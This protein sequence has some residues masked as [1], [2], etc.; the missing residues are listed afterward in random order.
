MEQGGPCGNHRNAPS[1]RH[2]YCVQTKPRA[3]AIALEHLQ[4]Q[5]FVCR[6]PRLR[7]CT[8]ERGHRHVR[9]EALFPR[10][11][12]LHA[13]ATEQSL[14]PVR[15]TRGALGLVRFGGLPALVPD[16]LIAELHHAADADDTL[17][18]HRHDARV[19]DRVCI[20]EGALAGLP[21]QFIEAPAA[22]RAVLLIELLGRSQRIEL[23]RHALYKLDADLAA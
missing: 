9:I 16:A 14:A 6:L 17:T 23:P 15:S 1:T 18:D 5:D 12:F 2:W 3:E 4:R 11:L 13:D 22:D 10:Y 7:R 20:V 21:A 8:I 19:G